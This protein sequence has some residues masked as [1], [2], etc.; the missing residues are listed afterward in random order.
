LTGWRSRV[1][2]DADRDREEHTRRKKIREDERRATFAG[3]VGSAVS[4]VP[5]VI[6]A[7]RAH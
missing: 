2:I 5:S 6:S 7:K 3:K 4:P 1:K